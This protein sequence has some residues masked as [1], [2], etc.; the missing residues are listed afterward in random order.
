MFH[1]VADTEA[2]RHFFYQSLATEKQNPH[3]NLHLINL[4][5]KS[6]KEEYL[7]TLI[8]VVFLEIVLRCRGKI[9]SPV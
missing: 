6:L 1:R 4:S 9:T 3:D 7:L 5:I 2:S 8:R